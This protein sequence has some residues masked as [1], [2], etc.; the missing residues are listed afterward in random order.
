[1]E[2]CVFIGYP[3]GYKGWKFYNPGN[4]KVVISKRADFDEH[5]FMLQRNSEPHLPPP[6]P[7]T[8]LEMPPTFIS[9]PDMLD[10]SLD[11]SQA[12][13]KPVHGGDGPTA[14]DLPSVAPASP[15]SPLA[16]FQTPASP[17]IHSLLLL[18]LLL[19]L[20]PQ[21]LPLAPSA[22]GIQEISGSQSNELFQ[23][24]T[25][26]QESL[27]QLWSPQMKQ[28]ATLITP[29]TS[30]KLVPPPHLSSPLT[31]SPSSAQMQNCGRKLVRKRWR[32]TES[33]GLGRSSNCPLGSMQLAPDGS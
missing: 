6:H 33:M 32:L 5:Y 13:Q 17:I 16:C 22:S 18:L 25:N 14:S 21:L 24:V 29:L 20:H 27:H 15:P 12:P 9:L 26:C 8:L 11:A 2:K 3:A 19:L 30:S 31:G 23:S 4:K 10:D 28:T 1:M 7:D